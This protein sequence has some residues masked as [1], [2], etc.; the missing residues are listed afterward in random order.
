MHQ[1]F[2]KDIGARYK[3]IVHRMILIGWITLRGFC[4][5][6]LASPCLS[7]QTRWPWNFLSLPVPWLWWQGQFSLA[8]GA[9]IFPGRMT[10]LHGEA[11]IGMGMRPRHRSF[12]CPL[13]LRSIH[14][15]TPPSRGGVMDPLFSFFVF[16]L[17]LNLHVINLNLIFNLDKLLLQ[18]QKMDNILRRLYKKVR[19]RPNKKKNNITKN[20]NE[21]R[22]SPVR[23]IWSKSIES[24]VRI[25]TL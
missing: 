7:H 3:A 19:Q 22:S 10:G 13:T 4:L 17:C 2:W 6:L 12:L 15:G 25:W 24:G 18:V 8:M 23:K 1:I 20:C 16:R 5:L 9:L 11:P 21:I 14:S